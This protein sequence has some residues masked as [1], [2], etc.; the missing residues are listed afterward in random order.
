MSDGGRT[1]AP[2]AG[3]GRVVRLD[4]PLSLW[5]GFDPRTGVVIDGRHPQAGRCLTGLVVVM[6]GGKGS[7]SSSS[8]LAEAVRAGTSPVA[9]VLSEP[10]PILAIGSIVAAELYGRAVP[11]VTLDRAA[12]GAIPDGGTV[13][14]EATGDP[15]VVRPTG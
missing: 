7:S 15:P 8:V 6:P 3:A 13:E 4:G 9:F 10:D 2:G 12:F 14:V 11:V 5:G 1:L